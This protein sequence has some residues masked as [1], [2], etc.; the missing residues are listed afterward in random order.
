MRWHI[1]ELCK[2]HD[3]EIF[4]SGVSGRGRAWMRTRKIQVGKISS[5]ISYVVALHE[6]GHIMDTENTSKQDREIFAWEW[7]MDNALVWND[8]CQEKME[9]CLASYAIAF[10]KKFVR[11]SDG[12]KKYVPFLS[13]APGKEDTHYGVRYGKYLA[14]I[15]K[16]IVDGGPVF[17]KVFWS[18]MN[19]KT[20]AAV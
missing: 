2:E 10:A 8:R 14:N 7:A 5:V 18:R 19:S 13:P 6:I 11:W 15:P 3:I 12:M 16:G 9:Q 17:G 4:E 20:M 1:L